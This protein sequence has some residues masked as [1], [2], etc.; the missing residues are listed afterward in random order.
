MDKKE[1]DVRVRVQVLRQFYRDLAT[2]VAINLI[3]VMVWAFSGAGFF[4]PVFVMAGWGVGLV[5]KAADLGLMPVLKDMLPFLNDDWEDR[6]VKRML[7]D[8]SEGASNVAYKAPAKA[9]EKK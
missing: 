4:W 9:K 8:S 3:F 6:E 7:K 1:I 2:Y 5:L